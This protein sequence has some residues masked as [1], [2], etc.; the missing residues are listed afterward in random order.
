MHVLESSFH[1]KPSLHPL[2]L[3]SSEQPSL[4]LTAHAVT[5]HK[6]NKQLNMRL[7]LHNLKETKDTG[8]YILCLKKTSSMSLA[9]TSESIVGVS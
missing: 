5:V 6:Q 8:L 9:I 4:Q 7:P 1:E 3:P 2:H